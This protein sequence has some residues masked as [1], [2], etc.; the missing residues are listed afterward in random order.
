MIP[1]LLSILELSTPIVRIICHYID[2]RLLFEETEQTNIASYDFAQ[3]S[4][5]VKVKD[6]RAQGIGGFLTGLVLWERC[7]IPS[8][9]Y[10]CSTWAGW[11]S[12]RRRPKP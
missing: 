3:H 12:A 6:Y 1:V 7:A 9:L 8:L 10:N 11:R 2:I 4:I 5:K